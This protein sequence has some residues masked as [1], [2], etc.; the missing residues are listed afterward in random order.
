MDGLSGM[1][2]LEARP[3]TAVVVAM[4]G[5]VFCEIEGCCDVVF[6]TGAVL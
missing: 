4:G 2:S 5:P 1:P 3:A 6:D